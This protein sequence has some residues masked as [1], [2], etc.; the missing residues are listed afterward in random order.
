MKTDDFISALAADLP[1]KPIST[2]RALVIATL[3]AAPLAF[4]A[5]VFGLKV[6]PDL[7]QVFTSPRMA[8]KFSVTLAAFVSGVWLSLRLS[9]PDANVGLAWVVLAGI[10]GAI[11]VA[12][13]TEL[14]VLPVPSWSAALWGDSALKC[15]VLIPTVSAVPFV[16]VML[17]MKTGA[18]HTP[19]L[20]G[21]AAGLL[22]A[23][24]GATLYATHCQNDS[25][26]YI[27]VWYVMG[28]AIVTL[29][30]AVIGARVLRW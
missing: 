9:R 19:M 18:P 1:S 10:A 28:I 22:S 20:A 13:A 5:V 4:A 3:I 29:A 21:A 11:G 2:G 16:A 30:G 25:P 6:R 26:L 7:A 8:F 27:A 15:L 14:L 17:A 12:V 24:I 23:G